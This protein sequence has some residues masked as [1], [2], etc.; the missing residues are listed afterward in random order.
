MSTRKRA[1]PPVSCPLGAEAVRVHPTGLPCW[2]PTPCHLQTPCFLPALS[3]QR[4][5]DSQPLPQVQQAKLS[6]R[7]QGAASWPGQ[8]PASQQAP[9]QR[10]RPQ[11]PPCQPFPTKGLPSVPSQRISE[12]TLF[13]GSQPTAAA[14]VGPGRPLTVSIPRIFSSFSWC[15]NYRSDPWFPEKYGCHPSWGTGPAMKMSGRV[16]S[17]GAGHSEPG[18]LPP[19]AV[20]LLVPRPPCQ[21]RCTGRTHVGSPSRLPHGVPAPRKLSAGPN[22]ESQ[23]ELASKCSPQNVPHPC[24]PGLVRAA[25]PRAS[26]HSCSIGICRSRST[27]LVA[28]PLHRPSHRPSHTARQCSHPEAG[29]TGSAGRSASARGTLWR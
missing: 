16:P 26:G 15:Q 20:W 5:P 23:R 6:L 18:P 29:V 13:S 8:W 7:D 22:R 24:P 11:L 3:F 25:E 27:G 4:V 17:E 12:S 10:T 1:P 19:R 2:P 14:P 9:W 28:W 21:R